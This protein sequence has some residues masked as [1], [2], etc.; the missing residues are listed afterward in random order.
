MRTLLAGLVLVL[1]LVAG[2]CGGDSGDSGD[3]GFS[4]DEISNALG[5]RSNG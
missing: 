2:G 3:S 1:L 4:D 5:L